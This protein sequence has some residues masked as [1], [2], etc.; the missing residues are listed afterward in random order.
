MLSTQTERGTAATS[1]FDRLRGDETVGNRVR[2]IE[3]LCDA[4]LEW[5]K[6]PISKD[7]VYKNKSRASRFKIPDNLSIRKVTQL[8]IPVT[9]AHTPLDLTMKYNDC[10][11]IDRYEPTFATAGGINLPKI[12]ICHGSDG[13][14]YKQLVRT[15][16]EFLYKCLL[17]ISSKGK[18][19]MICDRMRS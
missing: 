6:F 16:F 18:G 2:D 19:M 12:S 9:T 3:R 4:C 17:P 8:R 5:A 1:I 15:P 11:W 13:Q 7:S 14:K 10:V